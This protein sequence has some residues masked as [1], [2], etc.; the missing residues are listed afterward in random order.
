MEPCL[1]SIAIFKKVTVSGPGVGA[2]KLVIWRSCCTGLFNSFGGIF[3]NLWLHLS[4]LG[5][6]AFMV[7]NLRSCDKNSAFMERYLVCHLCSSLDHD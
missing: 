2:S 3:Q 7:L 1:L 6:L 4:L 5:C